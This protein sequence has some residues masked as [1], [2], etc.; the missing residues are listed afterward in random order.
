V[1]V[2][3]VDC[4]LFMSLLLFSNVLLKYIDGVLL[5]LA[6]LLLLLPQV[7]VGGVQVLR[8]AAAAGLQLLSVEQLRLMERG[9]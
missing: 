8:P 5:L 9:Q 2:V 7:T 1:V 3:V 4:W 6:L